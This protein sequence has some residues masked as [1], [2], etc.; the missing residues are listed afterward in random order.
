VKDSLKDIINALPFLKLIIICICLAIFMTV[1]DWFDSRGYAIAFV[2]V[3]CVVG[4]HL[5]RKINK[6]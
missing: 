4:E 5:L 6:D 1:L 2:I 3:A